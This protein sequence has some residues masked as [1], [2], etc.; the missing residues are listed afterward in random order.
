M[1]PAKSS[2]VVVVAAI[3][4]SLVVLIGP[5]Q[6]VNPAGIRRARERVWLGAQ[7]ALA[8]HERHHTFQALTARRAEALRPR[9][10]WTEDTFPDRFNNEVA[11][12]RADRLMLMVTRT[13]G[14]DHW[15]CTVTRGNGD[16][17]TGHGRSYFGLETPSRCKGDQDWATGRTA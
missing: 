5:A 12:F 14:T 17:I 11:L 4:V 8:Y 7:M 16:I 6:A 10:E 2:V 9:L 15:H 3:I 1:K 13:H